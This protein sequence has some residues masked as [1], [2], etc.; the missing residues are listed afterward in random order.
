[1]SPKGRK[2][3]DAGLTVQDKLSLPNSVK[4][5]KANKNW[6]LEKFGIKDNRSSRQ[7]EEYITQR[8]ILREAGDIKGLKEL[9]KSQIGKDKLDISGMD[10]NIKETLL[11]KQI[12]IIGDGITAQILASHHK[13][14]NRNA[15]GQVLDRARGEVHGFRAGKPKGLA[16][17]VLEGK[18]FEL[19]T[20]TFKVVQSSEFESILKRNLKLNYTEK[21]VENGEVIAK[22]FKEYFEKFPHEGFVENFGIKDIEKMSKEINNEFQY[23]EITPLKIA[24]KVANVM[25]FQSDL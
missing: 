4:S 5:S 10:R 25:E 3:A 8:D 1:M 23:G 2:K 16:S 9:T 15:A 12:E 17:K 11:P 24:A 18:R 20:E 7:I 22:T 6:Y 14:L 19:Q 21:E 13:D